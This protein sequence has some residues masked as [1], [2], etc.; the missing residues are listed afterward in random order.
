M[1]FESLTERFS[2]I[3]KKVR[4]QSRL[5]EKNMDEM[6]Q[7]VR[8]AL[9]EADVNFKVVKEFVNNIKEKALG[10]KVYD[11]LN[12]GQMVVKIVNDELVELL[13][14]TDTEL[15][16]EKNKPTII[17][18]V[19]LQ[20]TGKTTTAGKLALHFKKK[21]NKRVL[22][23]AADVYRPAAID[24]LDTLAKQV[25]VDIVNLGDKVSP[26]EIAKAAKKKAYDDRYDVLIIDTAGRLTIDETLMTELKL[27]KAAVTPTEIL[28]LVDAMSGQD[29]VNTALSF[30]EK[31]GLT[32]AIMSKLDSDARGGAALSI[33]HLTGVPIKF[34][35]VGETLEDLDIFY[36]DRMA[37][38]ILGMGDVLTLVE[39]A[40]QQLDEKT[41]KKTTRKIMEGEFDL[42]DMLEQMKQVQKLGKLGGILKLIPGMPKITPEQQELAEREMKLFEVIINSMTPEERSNPAILRN[43]RKV[44][45]AK[46]SGTS[47]QEINKVIKKYEQMKQMMKQMKG[48]KKGGP[49]PPG[50]PGMGR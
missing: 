17:M 10:T 47:N 26:V 30:N 18:L 20:G 11:T 50:F 48:Y 44:R 24:Q 36:P 16:F 25:G 14:S 39:K 37:D 46:G 38:R 2:K 5:T 35:G 7:E 34:A 1:A 21:M 31:L 4:G 43:S 12:P 22:L 13:G 33:K 19:G 3:L 41:V 45:I 40:Q 49:M 29:A 32:G 23:A 27:M 8:I 42:N 9:F 28:L 6:L 15:I